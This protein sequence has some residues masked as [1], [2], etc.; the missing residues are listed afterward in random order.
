MPSP[1]ITVY[2]TQSPRKSATNT[3]NMSRQRRQPPAADLVAIQPGSEY[4][5]AGANPL[6]EDSTAAF[7]G[8]MQ[9]FMESMT[10][11]IATAITTA[12][13]NEANIAA[14]AATAVRTNPKAVV[15]IS[16]S[17]DPFENMS[18]DMDMRG[19][20]ALWYTITRMSGAWPKAGVGVIVANAEALQDIIRNKVTSYGLD[21]STEIPT[22]GTRALESASKTIGGKDYANVNLGNFVSFLDKIHQV[23][24]DDVRNF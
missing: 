1:F 6:V 13:T 15:L 11:D 12:S 18:T 24:L 9:P 8:I 7:A 16:S 17:I 21:R 19:G 20:K 3:E 2:Q 22:T 10:A 23:N 4:L 14:S 5:Y